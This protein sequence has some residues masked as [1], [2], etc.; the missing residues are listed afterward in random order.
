MKAKLRLILSI[1]ICLGASAGAYWWASSLMDSVYA[2]H[3]PLKNNPPPPGSPVGNPLTTRVIFVLIDGLRLD[4]ALQTEVMPNLAELRQQ[5]AWATMHSQPPSYSQAGYT[6][7]L[8][9]SWPDI[10]DG[11]ALNLDYDDIFTFTQDDVISAAHR[12]GLCTAVSAFNWFERL[13]PP[14]SVYAAYYTSGEDHY[15]DL[16]VL[17]AAFPWIASG[18]YHFI[19]IH[20]DQLDYAGHYEGGPIDPRWNEAATR[21]D[22][23]LAQIVALMDLAQDTLLITSDHGHIDRGGHGGHE[24][25]TLIEP[26]LLVGAGI[27]PG[28]YND[29]NMVDVAPTLA[30]LLGTNLPASSQGRVLTKM[31]TLQ[32]EQ[33]N[34]IGEAEVNQ[35]KL[36]VEAYLTAIGSQ[37]AIHPNAENVAAYQAILDSAR[38]DRLNSER[39]PRAFLAIGLAF[40]PAIILYTRRDRQLLWLIVGAILFLGL[41][42]LRYLILGN[43]TY[44]LSSV[45]SA[46]ELILFTSSS[47]FIALL[48][49][50]LVISLRLGSFRRPPLEAAQLTSNLLLVT[51][52]LLALPV[53]WSFTLNSATITWTLPDFSSMF[54]AFI[55]LIQILVVGVFGVVLLGITAGVSKTFLFLRSR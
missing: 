2:Y 21:I 34:F 1:L 39:L 30:A 36:L 44:S 38:S 49:S 5:G 33:I 41:F 55:S 45:P 32:P 18:E 25:I 46:D 3:S 11:P 42:N 16:E 15:A 23:M 6:T 50:W 53:L 8:T 48:V 54:I 19:L 52:Y 13:I 7:L 10:N 37:T 4:T 22:Q 29:V 26:F 40:I 14:A 43:W 17:E 12:A 9:G 35:Q 27:Q 24:P 28:L 20:L 51:I 31:L 47:A